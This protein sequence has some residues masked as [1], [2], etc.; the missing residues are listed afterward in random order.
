MK[1]ANRASLYL[2][3]IAMQLLPLA[4]DLLQRDLSSDCGWAT[5]IERQHVFAFCLDDIQLENHTLLV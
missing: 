2:P 5:V 1:D 4:K 3:Y